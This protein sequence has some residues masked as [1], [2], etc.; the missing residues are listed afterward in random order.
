MP[1]L[2][3]FR[4]P[5]GSGK[6]TAARV[7][8]ADLGFTLVEADMYFMHDGTYRFAPEKLPTAHAWCLG[9]V[10]RLLK[11]GRDVAVANTFV[12]VCDFTPYL[13]AALDLGCTFEVIECRG[14]WTN[15]HAVPVDLV[16]RMRVEMEPFP[17]TML[18]S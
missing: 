18:F 8:E 6:S 2:L 14:T 15:V 13:Q 5:P 3:V 4:G 10:I 7:A 9:E 17:A 16:R 11:E 12:R 1:K